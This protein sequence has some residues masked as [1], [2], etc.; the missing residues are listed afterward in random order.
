MKTPPVILE[1]HVRFM[2]YDLAPGC[3]QDGVP[4]IA[5]FSPNFN[6]SM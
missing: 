5:D 1:V 3:I 2:L 4:V 6:S